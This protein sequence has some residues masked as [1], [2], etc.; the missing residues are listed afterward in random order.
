MITDWERVAHIVDGTL[1]SIIGP[2][3]A[4]KILADAIETSQCLTTTEA[5]RVL[6]ISCVRVRQLIEAGRLQAQ[7]FGGDWR[8]T[9]ADVDNHERGA[10]GRKVTAEG[11]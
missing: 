7:K 11:G 10:P 2:K 8:I 9:Q 6:K 1:V 5:A 3:K 4:Q